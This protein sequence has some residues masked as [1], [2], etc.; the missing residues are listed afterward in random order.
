M[1]WLT[2]SK[3]LLCLTIAIASLGGFTVLKWETIRVNPL[4]SVIVA[5]ASTLAL[6][7]LGFG[8]KVWSDLEGRWT[9]SCADWLDARI[10]L[11][12]SRFR[13]TYY[14][15]LKY[16]YRFFNVGGLRTQGMFT[17]ELERVFVELRI[18]AQSPHEGNAD[19]LRR[20]IKPGHHN[21]WELLSLES[22]TFGCL[23]VIG[24]RLR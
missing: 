13:R 19:P 7:L 20:T 8:K 1:E 10:R 5:A 4:T 2:K 17:P 6:A 3:R 9:K 15:H 22:D 16:R 23:V 18:A 24:A 14:T 12:V 11:F 21:V